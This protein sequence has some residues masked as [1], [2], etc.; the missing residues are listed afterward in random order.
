[1]SNQQLIPIMREDEQLTPIMREDEHRNIFDDVV[2]EKYAFQFVGTTNSTQ[3]HTTTAKSVT[4]K[5][6][7][8]Q[9]L[10]DASEV[11]I[12]QISKD[13]SE[14]IKKQPPHHQKT[15]PFDGPGRT[16]QK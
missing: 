11:T 15:N 9:F 6:Y 13:R 12:Q 16:L 8:T 1:M 5:E 10:G 3:G 2:A 7:A 14:I 4:A